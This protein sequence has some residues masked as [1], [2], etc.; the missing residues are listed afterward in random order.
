EPTEILHRI[1]SGEEERQ[2][3]LGRLNYRNA[4]ETALNGKQRYFVVSCGIGFDAAV[5]EESLRTKDK[6]FFNRIGLGA[7]SYGFLCVKR[8]LLSKG[9][10]FQI[11]LDGKRIHAVQDSLFVAVMN[12][13]YQGGGVM[14]TPDAVDDDGELDVCF[15]DR[16]SR[17][18]VLTVFPKAYSGAHVGTPGIR[19]DKARKIRIISSE[20]LYV[21]TDGEVQTKATDISVRC[22]PGK[23][24][25]LV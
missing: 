3:D 21:H 10:D 18:Q 2:I 5:C 11:T 8:L 9:V 7:L 1:L 6:A 15:T 12:H 17:L 13:K 16:M 23:L 25:L 4:E 20:P 24:R 19:I 22:L 14:F